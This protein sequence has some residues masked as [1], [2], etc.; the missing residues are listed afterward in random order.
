LPR[1][2]A[3][4]EMRRWRAVFRDQVFGRTDARARLLGEAVDAAPARECMRRSQQRMPFRLAQDPVTLARVS[5]AAFLE[6]EA[7]IDQP[8]QTRIADGSVRLR[9]PGPGGLADAAERFDIGGIQLHRGGQMRRERLPRLARMHART[10]RQQHCE[11]DRTP[12]LGMQE[13]CDTTAY[14]GLI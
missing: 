5:G 13:Q 7:E 3:R 14:A 2:R 11:V 6:H 4:M 12:L 1:I 9:A 10:S 8:L